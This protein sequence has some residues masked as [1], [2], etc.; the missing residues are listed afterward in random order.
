MAEL[1]EMA[2]GPWALLL[3]VAGVV[4]LTLVVILALTAVFSSEPSRRKAAIDVLRVLWIRR[5]ASIRDGRS[6]PPLEP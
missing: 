2:Q 1:F 6:E 3:A 4:Y 5:A